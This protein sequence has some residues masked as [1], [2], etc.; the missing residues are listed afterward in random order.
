MSILWK[1]FQ[2]TRNAKS[3][4]K[5]PKDSIP[6]CTCLKVYECSLS[7][8][9]SIY[10]STSIYFSISQSIHFFHLPPPVTNTTEHRVPADTSNMNDPLSATRILCG[11][12]IL[13]T[14]ATFVGKIFFSH[15]EPNF[16]RT[17]LVSGLLVCVVLWCV[18]VLCPVLTIHYDLFVLVFRTVEFFFTWTCFSFFG[19][20][21]LWLLF[22]SFYSKFCWFEFFK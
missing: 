20:A 8:Y 21:M 14:I 2:E 9:L 4:K 10:L 22:F 16:Q 5:I 1:I 7:K 3:R 13:P 11:A 19:F 6:F 18:L 12:L 15:V 17:M